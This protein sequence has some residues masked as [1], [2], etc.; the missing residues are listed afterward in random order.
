MSYI[1]VKSYAVEWGDAALD[2]A[3]ANVLT[4]VYRALAVELLGRQWGGAEI[5]VE[6]DRRVSGGDTAIHVSDDL[7]GERRRI[8]VTLGEAWEATLRLVDA[9]KG[10]G[11]GAY[12]HRRDAE[13]PEDGAEYMAAARAALEWAEEGCD[14][15]QADRWLAAGV[16]AAD[17]AERLRA[18]G[19][20][21]EQAGTTD[22]EAYEGG[23]LG[24]AVANG[25]LSANDV[26]RAL[27]VDE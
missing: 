1:H 17:A 14:D 25:D 23:T 3:T 13:D 4:D 24:Y 11:P 22:R 2:K 15:K 7:D 16:F 10:A 9:L 19:V 21:P 5:E 20:T 6:I 8:E 27:G 26:L 12:D 18:A